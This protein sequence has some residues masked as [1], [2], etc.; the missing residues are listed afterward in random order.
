MGIL[1]ENIRINCF[2]EFVLYIIVIKMIKICYYK[3]YRY[4]G[5]YKELNTFY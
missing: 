2:I 3:D 5:T 4:T 1:T